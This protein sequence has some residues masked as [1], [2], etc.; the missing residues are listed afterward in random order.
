MGSNIDLSSNV[1]FP[2]PLA[3]HATKVSKGY[4]LQYAKSIYSQWGG[5]D[6]TGSLYNTR[7]R[8]FQ[9]NRDYANGTQ[10]TNIYKSI[11]TSLDPNNGDGALLSLDW[12]PVPIIPKFVKIV[13]NK[14]LSTEPYPNVEA[15]DP[16]SQSEKDKEKARV[17]ALVKNKDILREA[18]EMGLQTAADPDS[19]PET[20]EEAEI[21]FETN[22]KTQ[23]EI[24][25]QIA[26]RLTLSWNDFSERIYRRNVED[27]VNIGMAVVKRNNDP[28]YGIKEDYIDPVYFIHSLTDDPNFTDCIYMGH[29]RR[30]SIQELKRM[31]GTQFTEEEY[32]NMAVTVMN[33]MGNN[34]DRLS[35]SYYDSALG[36]YQFGYDQYTINML[37]FEFAS[38]DD[39]I[40]EK[41]E[42]RFGNMGFYYKGYE[43]KAPQQ[44]VYD[45]EP[46]Y[47]QNA[48]IYGGKYIIGTDYM[49]DYGLKKNIPKNIHDLSRPRFSYSAVAVNLRR[50][51][52][53]S[54]VSGIITFADQLQ[55]S[56]LK[57]QQAIA[58]AKP[59][60]LIVDIEGLEN[61]Q[62]GRGGEL[63]PLD[64]QDIYEQTGVFYY[65][66]KNPDGG[67][68]NPPIR[69]LDNSIRNI[70][71]LIGIYNHNLRMIRD[72]TG[73][74]E[75]VDGTTPKGDQLVGV[76]QQ[77]IAA[78]NNATY[79]ITNASMVLFRRVC[80]D[81]VR[82]LQIIPEKSVLFKAY[83]TA[84]GV[85][86]MKI[87]SSFKD[88]P[89]YNFGVR[90]VTEMD[91]QDKAYLEANI[92]AALSI[93]EINLED[94]IGIRQLKDVDQAERLLIVRRK[95]RMREKQEQA[96]QNS[97]MQAQMNAQVAQAASQGKI[98]ETAETAK[99]RMAEIAAETEA[100][101]QLLT[102]EYSLK[103]ELE[104][105]KAAATVQTASMQVAQQENLE[106]MKEDRKD[107]RVDKQA[108]AQS[109]L[110]SQRK[111]ERPELT[112][113]QEDDIMK[114]LL[115]E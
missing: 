63:Q 15:I 90:V 33:T 101:K 11:L 113:E 35:E 67:F 72:A 59:D 87:L 26:T 46:V 70:N 4:G 10:D 6:T 27:L 32:K 74:N 40:F 49:F 105:Q 109:K 69:P 52:P 66:S 78:A 47:M 86:N 97:Q 71:E 98:A 2:D 84:I 115:Q 58:K 23:A 16:L 94:A 80:E 68:Q 14:I 36:V 65:R 92:Q 41:K 34:P 96:A 110:I 5:V 19:L 64:I 25:A 18:K 102:L 56:H 22:I 112:D 62:L 8:E 43:Y 54:M 85:E 81:I 17:R 106:K 38:V 75:V 103:T 77:A 104:R 61:V 48:T 82:C 31:A 76:R 42:S 7:W 51:I 53:K 91:D 107:E 28:N 1:N 114:I 21:F 88:L 39:I 50:M 24:A 37:E 73:I 95:K 13:V 57:M 12:S 9:I 60:G 111:G 108:V 30:V 20:L 99:A 45:R 55:L 83:E 44:S 79:D 89:M 29:I 93:G 3:N 100:R